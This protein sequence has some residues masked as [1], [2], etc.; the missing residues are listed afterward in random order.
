[1]F[2]RKNKTQLLRLDYLEYNEEYKKKHNGVSL[3]REEVMAAGIIGIFLGWLGLHDIILRRWNRGV[4]HFGI[5]VLGFSIGFWSVIFGLGD[6][7]GQIAG[8]RKASGINLEVIMIAGFVICFLAAY[9]WGLVDSVYL[10]QNAKKFPT[11]AQANQPEPPR[12]EPYGPTQSYP[13]SENSGN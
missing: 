2:N 11:K 5:V 4:S 7:S 8:T 10:L 1:M 13:G 3:S 6:V 9:I 12:S